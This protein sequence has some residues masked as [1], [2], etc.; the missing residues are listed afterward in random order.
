MAVFDEEPAW[1]IDMSSRQ[2]VTVIRA[3]Q[4]HHSKPPEVRIDRFKQI[5][6]SHDLVETISQTVQLRKAGKSWM[7]KCPFHD[8]QTPSLSVSPE[9][10][11][12]YCFSCGKG[13]D[14]ITWLHLMGEL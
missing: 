10:Q 2:A 3:I 8:D 4:R 14:V 5:K 7:G 9:K 6:E 1:F 11:L 12:F 13:G